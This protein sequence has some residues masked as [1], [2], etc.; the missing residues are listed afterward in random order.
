M[1]SDVVRCFDVVRS[2]DVAR[3]FDEWATWYVLRLTRVRGTTFGIPSWCATTVAPFVEPQLVPRP[4]VRAT[5]VKAA[6]VAPGSVPLGYVILFDLRYVSRGS[7]ARGTVSRW[8]VAPTLVPPGYVIL[9][10]LRYGPRGT[11]ARGT[12]ARRERED[13]MVDISTSNST[14]DYLEILCSKLANVSL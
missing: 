14:P 1:S 13:T 3:S 2:F 10:V 7:V 9:F 5:R 4:F 12:V 6:S 8:S 11:V